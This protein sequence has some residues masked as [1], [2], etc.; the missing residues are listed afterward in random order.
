MIETKIKELMEKQRSLCAD[1]EALPPSETATLLVSKASDVAHQLQQMLWPH[2]GSDK[3]T[4]CTHCLAEFSNAEIQGVEACPKCGDKGI[5]MAVEQDVLIRI[6]VHELRILGIWAENHAVHM[7]NQHLDD[8]Y[9]K[10]MKDTVNAICDRIRKQLKASGKDAPLTMTAE[11][12]DIKAAGHD[13][14]LF[15]DGKEEV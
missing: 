11:M 1:I 6:N 5:P 10:P 12:Q 8:A 13:V 9:R 2:A 15:R 3:T 7:D 4:R 14:Q